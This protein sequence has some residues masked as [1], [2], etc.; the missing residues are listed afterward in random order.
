MKR[1]REREII[2]RSL[3]REKERDRDRDTEIWKARDR[4]ENKVRYS[5]SEISDIRGEKK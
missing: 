4:V 1:E 3:E 5:D 2:D